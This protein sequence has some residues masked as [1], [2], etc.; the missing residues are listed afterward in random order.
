MADNYK[1]GSLDLNIQTINSQTLSSLDSVIQ[2]L[3][4]INSLMLNNNKFLKNI[5]VGGNI[6]RVS[7][8]DN[9]RYTQ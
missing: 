3:T 9:K 7:S 4:T 8:S 1:V 2:K 5:G 6:N